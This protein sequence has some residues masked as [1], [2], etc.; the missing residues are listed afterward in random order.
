MAGV[1]GPVGSGGNWHR[2][3]IVQRHSDQAIAIGFAA[4]AELIVEHWVQRGPND[5]LF[6][7]LV[8]NHRHALELILKA[9]IRESAAR[10]RADG[11]NDTKVDQAKVDDWLVKDASHN[12][13]KL[14]TRLDML[15]TRLGLDKMPS[16]THGVLISLHQ[17][18]PGGDAFRYA[19]VK[20]LDGGC[21]DAPR[22]LL[23]A[24][25][26]LQALVDVVAMHDHFRDAFNLLS[27]G[28]MT[29]LENVAQFQAETAHEA[30]W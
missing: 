8:F 4:T 26:D 5:L 28:V 14:A 15:L 27:G 11:Y 20:G 29:V 17:L 7:P 25:E 12:L 30:G 18:D 2:N 16:E 9:A 13:H 6:E 24:A 10:L 3:A 1:F 23:A 19:K 22:P 21:Q